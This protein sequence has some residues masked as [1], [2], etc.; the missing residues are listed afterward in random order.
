MTAG[1]FIGLDRPL[2]ARFAMLMAIPAILGAGVLATLDLA[3][4]GNAGIAS[5]ALWGG[6]L[7][8]LSALAAIWLLMRWLARQSYTPFVVYRVLLGLAVLGLL[9]SH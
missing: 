6:L 8:F 3:S 5:Y 7:A 2:S 1:R 4:S 9:A